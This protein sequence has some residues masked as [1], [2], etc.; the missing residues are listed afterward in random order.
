MKAI[1]Q[2]YEGYVTHLFVRV[3]FKLE[4][5]EWENALSLLNDMD[6][7]YDGYPL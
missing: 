2:I 7:K 6:K 5:V 4:L 1:L 3:L